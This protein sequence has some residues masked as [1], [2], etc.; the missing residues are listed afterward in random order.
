[1]E[2][3]PI[4]YWSLIGFGILTLMVILT[5]YLTYQFRKRLKKIPSEG[6]RSENKNLYK[7]NSDRDSNSIKHHHPRVVKQIRRKN[8]TDNPPNEQQ[9]RKERITV[10]NELLIK[11][12]SKD[13]RFNHN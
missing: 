9:T 11:E 10:L 8:Y 2:L 4:I 5:A 1:M 13:N 6:F 3:L 7:K 12:N